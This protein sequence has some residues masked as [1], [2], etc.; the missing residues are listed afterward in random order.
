MNALSTTFLRREEVARGTAAFHIGKPAGFRH[1]P[2]Q[3]LDVILPG[4]GAGAGAGAGK[5]PELRHTF[6]IVSAPHEAEI[7]FAT[8]MRDSEYKRTL[9]ALQPGATLSI[10]GPSGSMTL[11]SDGARPAVFIAGGIGITPFMSLLRHA[12]QERAARIFV[13]LYSNR[14]PDDAAFLAE[15]RDFERL[16]PSFRLIATMTNVNPAVWH[17][18]TGKIDAR[19]LGDIARPLPSPVYYVTG[20]PGM[21]GAMRGVLE[22]LGVADDDV[23][24]EEFFGY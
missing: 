14:A 22:G 1:K 11:H 12:A 17:G 24:S 20:P 21:V 13:L 7:V 4:A 23:R 15:L 6:S 8:R 3:A 10:E 19:L 16:L 9:G 18:P 5:A 2:G